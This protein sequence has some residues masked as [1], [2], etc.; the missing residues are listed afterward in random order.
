MPS[1]KTLWRSAAVGAL[2]CAVAMVA[3]VPVTARPAVPS[4]PAPDIHEHTRTIER[5]DGTIVEVRALIDHSRGDPVAT[6]DAL[7]P[8]SVEPDAGGG[9]AAF[10]LLR[11]WAAADLPRKVKYNPAGGPAGVDLGFATQYGIDAWNVVPSHSFRFTFA[12]TTSAKA[13]SCEGPLPEAEMDG[14]ITISWSADLVAPTIGLTCTYYIPASSGVPRAVESD[15]RLAL[16]PPEPWST[17]LPTPESRIDLMSL[18]SHELGHALGLDH[19]DVEGAVMKSGL[20]SATA[21]RIPTQ[22][23]EDGIRAL[24]G[25]GLPIPPPIDRTNLPKK[26]SIVLMSRE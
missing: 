1:A 19:S 10:A 18:V 5:Q 15:I 7:L 25:N 3:A 21:R 23:D 22:D 13:G 16:L 6:M 12:G 20:R 14:V 9:T 26:V 2:S 17:A 24:Y 11:K 4:S 8:G